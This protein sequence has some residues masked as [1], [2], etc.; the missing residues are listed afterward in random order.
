MSFLSFFNFSFIP[1]ALSSKAEKKGKER[2][3][4]MC[5]HFLATRILNLLEVESLLRAKHENRFMGTF[6][7]IID[8]K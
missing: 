4:T 3:C 8:F 6:K 7:N 2:K 1:P 5:I